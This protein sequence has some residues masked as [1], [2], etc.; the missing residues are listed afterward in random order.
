MKTVG[1]RGG[2]SWVFFGWVCAAQ[3]SKFGTCF[4]KNLLS[5]WY[6]VLEIGQFLTPHSRNC[7]TFN[8]PF[9]LKL[10]LCL[11]DSYIKIRQF[12]SCI[13]SLETQAQI[14]GMRKKSKWVG[15]N[16]SVL[17]L[18]SSSLF[19]PGHSRMPAFIKNNQIIFFFFL[20][21]RLLSQQEC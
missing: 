7:V 20:L 14:G 21:F 2:D 10:L 9:F 12:S 17:T 13:S 1:G 15:K 6:P 16:S 4:R 11:L 18:S 5:K 8:S 3:V 19:P